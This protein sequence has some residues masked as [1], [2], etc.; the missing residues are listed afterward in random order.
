MAPDHTPIKNLRLPP[1][2][3]TGYNCPIVPLGSVFPSQLRTG[4]YA[5]SLDTLAYGMDTGREGANARRSRR[6][7]CCA[8]WGLKRTT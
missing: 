5:T 3:L 6:A 7:V 4:A 8:A 2:A 1:G